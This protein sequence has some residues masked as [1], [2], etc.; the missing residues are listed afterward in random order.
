MCSNLCYLHP[1]DFQR[2]RKITGLYWDNFRCTRSMK[3]GRCTMEQINCHGLVPKSKK[4]QWP[5]T[6]TLGHS[7]RQPLASSRLP[8][9]FQRFQTY[10]DNFRRHRSRRIT[11]RPLDNGA[12]GANKLP[13]IG[14]EIQKTSMTSPTPNG[15]HLHASSGFQIYWD[16]FGQLSSNH[17]RRLH[18]GANRI[19]GIGF[20]FFLKNAE[21]VFRVSVP[22]QNCTCK[23]THKVQ[24]YT[25]FPPWGCPL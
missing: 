15:S 21:V 23:T 13:W 10:W 7:Q 2:F 25:H 1:A 4:P 19:A 8:L 11:N 18:T 17:K 20:R 9:N 5:G 3:N 16:N 6:I 22:L 14:S 12:S 24:N